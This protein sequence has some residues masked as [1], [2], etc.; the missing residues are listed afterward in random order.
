MLK[1]LEKDFDVTAL[2]WKDS[3]E[4]EIVV[5]K[6]YA[7]AVLLMCNIGNTHVY[8]RVAHTFILDHTYH[9]QLR[10]A[11]ACTRICPACICNVTW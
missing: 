10:V 8:S 2:M 5:D 1:E 4:N 3:L 6:V 9:T 11:W 7:C